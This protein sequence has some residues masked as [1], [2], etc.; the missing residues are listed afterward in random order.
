MDDKMNKNLNQ[1]IN[2]H[3]DHS[4][5][6]ELYSRDKDIRDLKAQIDQLKEEHQKQYAELRWEHTITK[7]AQ[8]KELKEQIRQELQSSTP[9]DIEEAV[10]KH[11]KNALGDAYN[12]YTALKKEVR[13]LNCEIVKHDVCIEETERRHHMNTLIFDGMRRNYNLTI[14]KDVAE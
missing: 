10:K 6:P 5:Y 4:L 13:N 9:K 2:A 3:F 1:R 14:K 12:N 7:E 8:I 11:T